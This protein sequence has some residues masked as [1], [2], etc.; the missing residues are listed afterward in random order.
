[1]DIV[2]QNDLMLRNEQ[3]ASKII[4]FRGVQTLLDRDLAEMYGVETKMLNQAVKRNAERFPDSFM[5]RL[6]NEEFKVLR[7]QFVTS[8][9]ET[10]GGVQYAPYA[11]T[12]QGVAML[13]A[14][15]RSERAIKVSIEIMNAFVYMRHNF[16]NSTVLAKRMDSI[17]LKTETRLLEHDIKLK[18]YDENFSKIFDALETHGKTKREGIFFQ[19]QIFDA[20]SFFQNLIEKATKSIV[21]I[22]GY[23]DLTVLERFSKKK[24]GVS[25]TIYTHPRTNIS[26]LDIDKFNE[27]YPI[28]IVKR[29]RSMHDRFLIIDNKDLYHIG[30]SLKDLGKACFAFEKMEDS[31]KMIPILLENCT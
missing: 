12:E 10:R 25:V 22:D 23:V 28:L 3:I 7:S 30:A 6:S 21:L 9:Q 27:Q 17:E 19:G 31:R 24:T 5:F 20:Y 13:S 1:M 18:E 14:I 15:L 16:L 11:F 4:V 29:T 26:E 8:K 2:D